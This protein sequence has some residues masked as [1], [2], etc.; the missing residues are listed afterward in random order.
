MYFIS[1]VEEYDVI[2]C[3]QE[4]IDGLKGTLKENN[5]SYE[6]VT[7]MTYGNI[8]DYFKA[9]ILQNKISFIEKYKMA[10]D[11]KTYDDLFLS[12]DKKKYRDISDAIII[13]FINDIIGDVRS[14]ITD[15]YTFFKEIV[16]LDY[17]EEFNNRFS[18]MLEN[19]GNELLIIDNTAAAEA[20]LSIL[21]N[22][23]IAVSL[24]N[25]LLSLFLVDIQL[26]DK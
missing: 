22:I 5:L 12:Q 19:Y 4:E 8:K 9:K 1:V 17:Y 21:D 24:R 26:S 15:A 2:E 25:D 3:V 14:T 20:Y 16:Q 6:K 23:E 7:S 13:H 11:D 18:E 10:I